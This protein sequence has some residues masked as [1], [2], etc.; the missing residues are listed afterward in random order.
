ML[1]PA[2]ADAAFALKPGSYSEPVKGPLGPVILYV[3]SVT[4]AKPSTFEGVKDD[5]R[6]KM[7]RETAQDQVY[8]VQNDIED[9]RAGGATME[10]IAAK[11]H[12]SILKFSDLTAKGTNLDGEK[13]D[14]L[15]DY[16]D[17]MK[18]V[19][20]SSEGDLIPPGDTGEGGYYWV[21]VDKVT[22]SA[23]KPLDTVRKDVVHLWKEETRKA[24]LKELAQSLADRGNKGESLEKIAASINR[25]AL[26]SPNLQRSS[27]S[28]TFSRLAVTRLFALPKGG[29][30]S[31]PVGYGDSLILMEATSIDQPAP[32]PTSKAYQTIQTSLDGAIKGDLL[33]AMIAGFEKKLGT[34][35]NTKLIDRMMSDNGQ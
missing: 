3:S 2:L 14:T 12:L 11:N 13:P 5:L 4:P 29:F 23:L 34:K 16:K 32:D 31:G 10:E 25:A 20:E 35:V 22:P 26:T 18:T 24:K 19:F 7:T 6:Q 33:V 21:R 27:Q 28:D 17:L 15:P 9:A 8:D 1:S 30:T